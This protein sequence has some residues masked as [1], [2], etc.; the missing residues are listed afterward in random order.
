VGPSRANKEETGAG[1]FLLAGV[2]ARAFGHLRATTEA[3]RDGPSPGGIHVEKIGRGSSGSAVLPTA[4]TRPRQ[5]ARAH[6]R[7]GVS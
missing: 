2:A 7:F 3:R 5:I 4:L 6:G 1:K